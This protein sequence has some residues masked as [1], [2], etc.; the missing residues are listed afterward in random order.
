MQG[1]TGESAN[2]VATL[3]QKTQQ[4]LTFLTVW[5]PITIIRPGDYTYNSDL[6]CNI[7]GI[8]QIWVGLFF[9]L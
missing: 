4:H 7:A 6:L 1:T 8:E 9:P 5:I 3:L 2:F